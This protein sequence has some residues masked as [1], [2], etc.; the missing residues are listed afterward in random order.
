MFVEE[1]PEG[2]GSPERVFGGDR[3]MMHGDKGPC[4]RCAA[5]SFE[6]SVHVS[7]GT[8]HKGPPAIMGGQGIGSWPEVDARTGWC[9]E[10]VERAEGVLGV[11]T[12][13]GVE[14]RVV[15]GSV[16]VR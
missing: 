6:D 7:R 9:W 16:A 3:G 5:F 10:F 13:S 12:E 1:L 8:C 2:D 11:P 15:H 14:A 4:G